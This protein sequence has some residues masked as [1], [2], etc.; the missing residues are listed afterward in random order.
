MS[1]PDAKNNPKAISPGSITH[2]RNDLMLPMDSLPYTLYVV[3][4]QPEFVVVYF[5]ESGTYTSPTDSKRHALRIIGPSA[6][7][8]LLPNC[9]MSRCR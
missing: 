3:P 2:Q 5:P 6:P 1:H 7:L 4:G 8:M 9:F